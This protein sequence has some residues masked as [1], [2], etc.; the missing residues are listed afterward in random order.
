ME[1]EGFTPTGTPPRENNFIRP[2]INGED[3]WKSIYDQIRAAR[4]TIHLCFWAMEN[5]L[6][7][8]RT[9]PD[10]FTGPT[11]RRENTLYRV[12]Y[13]RKRAGVKIRILL[14]DYPANA[15]MNFADTLIRLSGS[16]GD[17]EVMYQSHPSAIGS[18][19]QKYIVIDDSVAFVGGMNAKGNDWDTSEHNAIE[20]R[21]ADYPLSARDRRR[22]PRALD[23]NLTNPPR[24]DY[25]A[26]I[27]GPI[28]A[29]VQAN[30]VERWN[31]CLTQRLD[32]YRYAT[33]AA[34]PQIP[35]RMSNVKAQINRTV[36]D[37]PVTPGGEKGILEVYK[38]AIQEAEN[39]IYIEDQY[40]RSDE[41]ANEIS[42]AMTSNA[43]LK[44]IVVTPPD[45]WSD[46]DPDD[47]FAV[48]TP[49]TYWT[50]S[51]YNTIRASH[52]NF[53]FFFLQANYV[54]SARQRV[55]VPVDLH[56]KIMIVDDVW[57]TIGS[58]NINDRGFETDGELNVTVQHDSAGSFRKDI[59][60]YHLK[61]QCPDD[62]N[63]AVRL[64]YE[65][66]RA[67]NRAWAAGTEPRSM[68]FTYGFRGPLIPTLPSG[69]V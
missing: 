31:Y 57:Y 25:M 53:H 41:I 61:E 62:I 17:F 35:N 18:W 60:G 21:R 3:A 24:H 20:V 66:A 44:V 67:N 33:R 68:I 12:L 45:L 48:G 49:S 9:V 6:E 55:F 42:N 36:P 8:I 63:D 58:C 37:Y 23:H 2:L 50:Q 26:W 10:Q 43:A 39:Y 16:I 64:W 1:N 29:D 32:Y 27:A 59:F 13:E 40:F 7:L 30:F 11:R 28:A 4:E 14:W 52:S 56:A 5:D 51:A 65:H 22:I 54:N 19:H 69:W 46:I 34:P 38:K 15:R 47:W